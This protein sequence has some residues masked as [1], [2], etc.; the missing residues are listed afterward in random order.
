MHS[1][2]CCTLVAWPTHAPTEHPSCLSQWMS[3]VMCQ[4]P[5]MGPSS[6]LPGCQA[7]RQRPLRC[8]GLHTRAPGASAE[9]RQIVGILQVPCALHGAVLPGTG[10]PPDRRKG[11]AAGLQSIQGRADAAVVGADGCVGAQQQAVGVVAGRVLLRR[12]D[13]SAPS[14]QADLLP[15]ICQMQTVV[16]THSLKRTDALQSMMT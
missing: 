2:A 4:A 11:A 7:T 1:Q 6:H 5:C 15:R 8:H 9:L 16:L 3:P 14:A 12:A 13:R 10:L